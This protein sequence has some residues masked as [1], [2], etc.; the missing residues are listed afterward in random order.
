MTYELE[1]I[2]IATRDTNETE[3]Y[4]TLLMRTHGR[5][6]ALSRGAK[7][8]KAKLTPHVQPGNVGYFQF[9]PRRTVHEP[10]IVGV[11]VT[12]RGAL[13]AYMPEKALLLFYVLDLVSRVT[14]EHVADDVVYEY[15]SRIIALLAQHSADEVKWVVRSYELQ[16]LEMH[17]YTHVHSKEYGTMNVHTVSVRVVQ[18]LELLAEGDMRALHD[19]N[20]TVAEHNQIAVLLRDALMYHFDTQL[21]SYQFAPLP[22]FI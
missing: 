21:Y 9:I 5:M 14:L 3:Q 7:H 11:D 16:L 17:G 13:L 1:G 10:L 2:V 19:F 22:T 8:M 4:V 15:T 6:T 20:P 12:N 18:M